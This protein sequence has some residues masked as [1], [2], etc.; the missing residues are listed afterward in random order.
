MEIRS[1]LLN[2]NKMALVKES[3]LNVSNIDDK[4][5]FRVN[6]IEYI[7]DSSD[8]ED[9]EYFY[10][11]LEFVRFLDPSDEAVAY[12]DKYHL[13]WMNAPAG[14]NNLIGERI[15]QWDFVYDHECLHQLWDTFGVA[16]K[17]KSEGIKYDHE[18]L[19]IA[20]DCVINDYLYFIRK[21]ER[22]NNLITPEY[23]KENYDI[24]YNRKEDTQYTLYLKLLEKSEELKKDK[25][26][27]Q[28][29]D[30][31]QQGQ[32]QGQSQGQKQGQ[33][34]S[35]Q[36]GSSSSNNSNNEGAQEA[37]DRAQAAADKA[38]KAAEEAKKNDDKNA[39]EKQSAAE[40]AQKAA[41]EAQEAA[42][43]AKQAAKNGNGKEAGEQTK[44]A[45][46]AANKAEKAAEAAGAGETAQ[47]AAD[48]AQKA[49]DEAKKAAEDAKKNGDGDA[50]KKQK[51]AEDAQKAADEAKE[52]AEAAENANSLDEKNKEAKKA[53]EA[54]N[55]AEQKA[56]S[57]KGGGKEQ[58][59]GDG[60]GANEF[61]DVDLDEVKKKAEK[62]I[63]KYKERISGDLG[64]FLDK[65]RAALAL[66]ET[67]M[68]VEA[69]KSVSTWNKKLMM[70]TQA[71]IKN[72][73]F[74]KHREFKRTYQRPNRRAGIVKFGEP[75]QR[76]KKVKD[77]KLIINAAFYIDRSGS[78][79]GCIDDVFKSAYSISES[80]KKLFSRDKLVDNIE[81]KMYAWDDKMDEIEWGKKVNARGGTMDFDNLLKIIKEETNNYMINVIITDAGFQVN[82]AN[83]EKFLKEI[84]GCIIFITNDPNSNVKDIAEKTENRTK[85][86]YIQADA[87]FSID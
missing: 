18:I 39:S 59:H 77:D 53:K 41:D 79:S 12:T 34:S 31:Q 16:D 60:S 86:F 58:G 45:R 62:V 72:I 51:A 37:A 63:N 61:S 20:S 26:C 21:K 49:A 73:L 40:E 25:R 66:K 55:K 64:S 2:S 83:V 29:Q 15:R 85:L 67:G 65:C 10:D 50:D 23:L 6:L 71:Y 43:E 8:D 57:A 38:K 70:Q 9:D 30:Q 19:N 32:S 75:I 68:A 35:G 33:S 1:S 48:R 7:N 36:S 80:L 4:G 47:E 42:D 14:G 84:Y 28:A 78:M 76:G 27:Q 11:M 52:A 13:V 69:V 87:N 24:E 46:E 22:P 54:A 5:K 17:I 3:I 74:K 82:E 81:F 56:N 44:K